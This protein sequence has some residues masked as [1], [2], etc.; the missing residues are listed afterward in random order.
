MRPKCPHG[1][2]SRRWTITVDWAGL[3]PYTLWLVWL[4]ASRLLGISL[5]AVL[6]M[7]ALGYTAETAPSIHTLVSGVAILSISRA[8]RRGTY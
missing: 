3:A 1:T 5:I 4:F 6:L 7:M 8:L 2:L